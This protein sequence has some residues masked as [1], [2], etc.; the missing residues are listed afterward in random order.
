VRTIDQKKIFR[1]VD[2]NFNRA[3][4][5]LRVCEDICRFIYDEKD[6]T[7]RF[8]SVRHQLTDIIVSLKWSEMIGARNIEEDV[9]K[10]TTQSELKRSQVADIYYANAQRGKESVRVLEEF[11]KLLNVQASL[12]L[13]KLRYT[14]YALE[15]RL[16][17][18][19]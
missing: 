11:S 12:K 19:I 17:E 18:K 9:G 1:I 7:R 2:A 4:E 3:K 8:K 6:L 15:K 10:A 13:K 14:I 16:F 5:G